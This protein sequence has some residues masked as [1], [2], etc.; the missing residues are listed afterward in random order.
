MRTEDILHATDDELLA[1]FDHLA[2][3]V[4]MSLAPIQN[5]LQRRATHKLL[6]AIG[7]LDGSV[8]RLHESSERIE[9]LTWGLIAL[10]VV[11]LLAALPPAYDAL[12]HFLG[13]G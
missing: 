12:R 5:E 7:D 9:R 3:G 10:T 1:Q 4:G 8:R 13:R 2:P 6:A 11:L